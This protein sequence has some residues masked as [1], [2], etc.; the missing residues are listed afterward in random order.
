MKS[1]QTT[2]DED[3]GLKM[4]TIAHMTIG[5]REVENHMPYTSLA[6]FIA[7]LRQSTIKSNTNSLRV[8]KGPIWRGH[9]SLLSMR[10]VAC[11]LIIR[12]AVYVIL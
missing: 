5:S 11:R 1:L 10:E 8:Q 9:M 12:H 4:M 6:L 3:D 2:Y 7:N